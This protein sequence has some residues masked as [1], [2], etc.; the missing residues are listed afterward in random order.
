VREPSSAENST[1][2]ASERAS[3][4]ASTACLSASSAVIFS[5]YLRCSA[6]VAR[7]VWITG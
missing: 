7:K 4:T 6:D 1:S 3:V 5:L 2:G